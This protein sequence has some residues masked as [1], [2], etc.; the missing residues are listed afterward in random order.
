MQIDINRVFT[1]P[2]TQHFFFGYYDKSPLDSAN[3]RLLAQRAA[4]MDRMVAAD[5]VLELGYFDWREGGAFQQ[6]AQ[7]HAWNWQQGCMLQ[8]LGPDHNRQVLYNDRQDGRFVA[9]IHDLDSG[10]SRSLPMAV[11]T[12]NTQGTQALCID[13]ER[14]Y[15]FLGGYNYQ[16]VENPAKRENKHRIPVPIS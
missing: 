14:H 7:T 11:Y 6:L 3:G 2:P 5:D 15:W 1:T 16:G 4:F 12:V 10:T 9:V 13:N 8:W